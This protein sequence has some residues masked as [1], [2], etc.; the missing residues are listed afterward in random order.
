MDQ[1][2]V[3]VLVDSIALVSRQSCWCAKSVSVSVPPTQN[4]ATW[5]TLALG[6]ATLPPLI[7]P[8]M[9][10]SSYSDQLYEA[11]RVYPNMC[12]AYASLR[13]SG[14]FIAVGIQAPEIMM[15]FVGKVD[16]GKGIQYRNSKSLPLGL[17][18]WRSIPLDP[19]GL[20]FYNSDRKWPTARLST[21]TILY[22]KN[23]TS[24]TIVRVDFYAPD[25]H[26]KLTPFARVRNAFVSYLIINNWNPHV[27]SSRT[28]Y[29]F[30][31]VFLQSDLLLVSGFSTSP[32]GPGTWPGEVG[33]TRGRN[34][35]HTCH[36]KRRKLYG[37]PGNSLYRQTSTFHV[38]SPN[39]DLWV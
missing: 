28:K 4:S 2:P 5:S 18:V 3:K 37:Q 30:L 20:L 33:S 26:G 27:S 29:D 38:Q 12:I 22:Y 36:S 11:T 39:T 13:A 23:S 34:L 24:S 32:D 21:Y 31:G 6:P 9:S 17:F 10:D 19:K 16:F 14:D 15:Q 8:T 25:I 1:S 7:Q 35:P